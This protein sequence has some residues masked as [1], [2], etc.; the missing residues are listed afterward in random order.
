MARFTIKS[1]RT[2]VTLRDPLVMADIQQR[3]ER[4]RRTD[5]IDT[6]FVLIQCGAVS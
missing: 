2:C 4:C 3:E 1:T 5:G 6:A